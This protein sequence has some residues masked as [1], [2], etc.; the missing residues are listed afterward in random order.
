MYVGEVPKPKL[1]EENTLL[2]K[3][4]ASALNRADTSQRKG[5]YP[6]PPGC[7]D[8]LGLEMSGIIEQVGPAAEAAGWKV[9]DKICSLLGGGGYAE[10]VATPHAT[11]MRVPASIP[12]S[13]AAAL[14]EAFMTAWQAL[15]WLGGLT[16]TSKSVLIHA[17]ASGIGLSAIQ[18]V[19][20]YAPDCKIIITAGSQEKI[21]FCKKIGAHEGFNRKEG[22]WGPKVLASTENQGVSTIIDVV[23]ASYW[24]QNIDCI[25]LD[26]TMV[27]LSFL[28]GVAAPAFNIAPFLKRRITVRGTTLRTRSPS[29]KEKLTREVESF[30]FP[31]LESGKIKPIIAKT[32]PL[33]DIV[34]SHQYMEANL[35]IGKIVLKIA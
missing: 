22:P 11:A 20:N 24:Q 21:D 8:I 2:V 25:A 7:T 9:G 15:V 23:G 34:A 32:F 3:I 29:Y 4:T 10:Y 12:L 5:T 28:G 35:N 6:P 17:G 16:P 14:P 26:G 31:L 1:T 13:D 33:Q 30:L 27:I 18:I 19:K